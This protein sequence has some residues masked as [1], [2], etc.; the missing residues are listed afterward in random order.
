MTYGAAIGTIRRRLI[1]RREA[2]LSSH[3]NARTSRRHKSPMCEVVGS[4]ESL[5][6][7]IVSEGS[8]RAVDQ[9]FIGTTSVGIC[10]D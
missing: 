5:D 7:Y 3:A 2:T 6:A 8:A 9:R 10:T 1:R 4:R